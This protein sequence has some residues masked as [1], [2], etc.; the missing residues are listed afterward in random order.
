MKKVQRKFKALKL[1]FH[2]KGKKSKDDF[3]VNLPPEVLLQILYWVKRTP[4]TRYEVQEWIDSAGITDQTV[5]YNAL[6]QC[7][8]RYTLRKCALV[9][10]YWA[11]YARHAMF[12]G[13]TLSVET[14]ERAESFRHYST[15]GSKNLVRVCDLIKSIW[16]SVQL[17][18]TLRSFLPL[19]CFAETRTK[20]DRVSII[21]PFPDGY[22]PCKQDSPHWGLSNCAVPSPSGTPWR[23]V[24]VKA[25]RF[26]SYRHFFR[27]LSYFNATREFN[28]VELSW[29]GKP[30]DQLVFLKRSAAQYRDRFE[31]HAQSCRDNV[32][33]GLQVALMYPDCPLRSVTTRDQDWAVGLMK[34][35][36]E[37]Y[38]EI[39]PA[40]KEEEAVVNAFF[41]CKSSSFIFI[42]ACYSDM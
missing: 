9:C 31:I 15:N 8:A 37:F 38:Q 22:P 20:L 16:V 12:H 7:S 14:Y 1:S 2:R 29:E 19:L 5:I 40:A 4:T 25:I 33:T 11:N 24:G 32:V 3:V 39:P 35:V 34:L 42:V 21:G 41:S 18:K 30:P 26:P 36:G 27:F 23:R 10:I 13:A 6:L 17:P 28:L